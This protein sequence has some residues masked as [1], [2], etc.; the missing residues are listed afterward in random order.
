[1]APSTAYHELAV[2]PVERASERWQRDTMLA[3][4]LPVIGIAGT[5]GKTTVVRMLDAILSK[6]GMRTATWTDLGVEIRGRRQKGELSGWSL[7]LSRLAD[8]AI[9]VAIQELHWSTI[10]AV[11][12]PAMSYPV[13][14]LTNLTGGQADGWNP[15]TLR[16]ATNAATRVADAAHPAGTLVINGDDYSLVDAATA[17]KAATIVIARSKES[18]SLSR[19]L[20]AG[21]AAVWNGFDGIVMSP[22][23][24][25]PLIPLV[26]PDDVPATMHGS[27][28]FQINNAMTAAAIASAIGVDASDIQAGLRSFRTDPELMPGSFNHWENASLR[29]VVSQLA[30]SWQT[31]LVLRSI[32]PGARRRQ[33]TVVGD[34]GTIEMSDI[35]ETGRVLGRYPGAILLYENTDQQR[36]DAFR[37]GIT[38]NE[39]PPLIV[40][41]PTERKAIN[42]ALRTV[43]EDDVLLM[44]PSGDPSVACRAITRFM[45]QANK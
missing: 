24:G 23:R 36:L 33:I 16:N 8:G 31:R 43:R 13:L 28:T 32:N 15:I 26:D 29:T 7:A 25:A 6:A 11:G 22:G 41:L 42:R 38:A 9:D 39:Y 44:L 21:G 1:M 4:M 34:L 10:H 12:L 45:D 27:A 19:Q 5:G 30:S 35:V 20:K 3:G 14:A 40:H 37:H 17:T 2:A 18:P